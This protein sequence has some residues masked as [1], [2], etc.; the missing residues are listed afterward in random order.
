M[1]YTTCFDLT[2]PLSVIS[3]YKNTSL[4]FNRKKKFPIR[5][6][7]NFQYEVFFI[8]SLFIIRIVH[9]INQNN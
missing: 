7:F 8:M 6:R 3:N 5:M 1:K 9:E 2:R 4:K